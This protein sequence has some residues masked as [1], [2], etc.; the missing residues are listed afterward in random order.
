[1]P[2]RKRF[3]TYKG[4]DR[5]PLTESSNSGVN[6]CEEEPPIEPPNPLAIEPSYPLL[7]L[8]STPERALEEPKDNYSTSQESEIVER[9]GVVT[10]SDEMTEQLV[11][12]LLEIFEKGG[13]AD[14]SFKKSAFEQALTNV[15]KEYRGTGVLTHEKMKNKW[16]DLKSKWA[17]W[18]ALSEH[19][20]VGWNDDEERFEAAQYAWDKLNIAHPGIIWHRGHIM[21]F[22]EPLST[23]LHDVQANGKG[24]F[25]LAT[26]TPIDPC[27]KIKP[28][29]YLRQK[30]HTNGR[31]SEVVQRLLIALT[32][33]QGSQRRLI[34]G[35][36]LKGI[37]E[38][39]NERDRLK[40]S[41][42][43]I[44]NKL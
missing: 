11:E 10:W 15:R 39:Y 12:T 29:I 41:A 17:H 19:S 35:A 3:P 1:M 38:S 7:P 8:L 6:L 18:K 5:S 34:L 36:P 32:I 44:S 42:K 40:R 31:E 2:P 16:Q 21:P 24:A 26:R 25:S 14:N 22:R 9:P 43:L 37:P 33:R 23:I 20:G 13:A 28:P 4:L 30:H 27:S